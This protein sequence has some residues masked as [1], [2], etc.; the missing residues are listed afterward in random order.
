MIWLV[1]LAWFIARTLQQ[2]KCTAGC[3]KCDSSQENCLLCDFQQGMILDTGACIRAV[4]PG[5]LSYTFDGA[6]TACN[7]TTYLSPTGSCVGVPSGQTIANCKQYGSAS[8]CAICDEGYYVSKQKCDKLDNRIYGCLIHK[9]DTP[10]VCAVCKEGFRPSRDSQAC[11]P[12]PKIDN[13]R[14]YSD[15]LCVKCKQSY[16]ITPNNYIY[17]LTDTPPGT[18]ASTAG[19][20]ELLSNSQTHLLRSCRFSQIDNCVVYENFSRCKTCKENYF[21]SSEGRCVIFPTDSIVNCEVYVAAFVCGQ[22][23]QGYYL[24][25]KVSCL[26]VTP[27]DNCQLYNTTT[28]KSQCSECLPT[29][30]LSILSGYVCIARKVV[31]NNCKTYN[32]TSELCLICNP[33]FVT[34]DDKLQCLSMIQ[35][36]KIYDPSNRYTSALSCQFCVTG[37][38]FNSTSGLCQVGTVANCL[39]YSKNNACFTCENTYYLSNSAC[40]NHLP[41]PKC[42]TYSQSAANTC[43]TCVA[44]SFNFNLPSTCTQIPNLIPNCNSYQ[45]LTQC[46]KCALGYYLDSTYTCQLI[47]VSLNCLVLDQSGACIQCKT[48][49]VISKGLCVSISA[50]IT[51]N[52]GLNNADGLSSLANFACSYCRQNYIPVNF[53][54]LYECLPPSTVTSLINNCVRYEYNAQASSYSCLGCAPGYFLD[55]FGA[56]QTAC[57]VSDSAMSARSLAVIKKLDTGKYYMSLNSTINFCESNAN[58]N[59]FCTATAPPAF[60]FDQDTPTTLVSFCYR[61]N[62]QNNLIV[63]D[64]LLN[65]VGGLS[66]SNA[67][68]NFDPAEARA[69]SPMMNAVFPAKWCIS[70]SVTVK[71]SQ[72]PSNLV[73]NCQYYSNLKF[74]G[75]S[76]DIIGCL[77]CKFGFN[78]VVMNDNPG[79]FVG[80][81]SSCSAMAECDSTKYYQG[82]TASPQDLMY[83]RLPLTTYFSCHVCATAGM[84]PGIGLDFFTN[85]GYS[86]SNRRITYRTA[87]LNPFSTSVTGSTTLRSGSGGMSTAC[88]DPNGSNYG[89][90]INPGLPSKCGLMIF[91]IYAYFVSSLTQT[92]SSSP[93]IEILPVYCAACSPGYRPT[94][95]GQTTTA[96]VPYMVTACT[97]IS[98]CNMTDT[99]NWFNSCSKCN[100]GYTWEW[101]NGLSVP[102]L[103]SCVATN[104]ANCAYFNVATGKCMYCAS[105]YFFSDVMNACE[106]I[107][108]T[109][110]SDPSVVYSNQTFVMP[111]D[112][113]R[114]NYAATLFYLTPNPMSCTSCIN[115]FIAVKQYK[116]D[117]ICSRSAL[118]TAGAAYITGCQNHYYNSNK[119]ITCLICSADYVLS[120]GGICFINTKL[121]NC[122]LASSETVCDQCKTGFIFLNQACVKGSIANCLTYTF[123][124]LSNTQ[125]CAQC[126]SYYYSTSSACARGEIPFC[127]TYR[128]QY[129]C[130]ACEPGYAPVTTAN[131]RS[132]CYMIDPALKCSSFSTDIQNGI[133][134]C[135]TCNIGHVAL[136]SSLVPSSYCMPVQLVNNCATYN[137]GNTIAS[138]TFQCTTCSTNYYMSSINTCIPRTKIDKNCLKIDPNNDRCLTCSPGYFLGPNFLDCIANPTGIL[139]CLIYQDASTCT[140]CRSEYYPSSKICVKL[141]PEAIISNCQY[142]ASLVACA[143]CKQ[144]YALINNKCEQANIDNCSVYV[145]KNNCQTCAE[146]HAL[147]N[148]NGTAVCVSIELQNCKTYTTV[149]PARCIECDLPFYPDINGICQMVNVTIPNCE[150]YETQKTCLRCNVG[151]LLS[152]DRKSCL[153]GGVWTLAMDPNC[154]E[155][156]IITPPACSTCQLGYYFSEGKCIACTIENC[157]LCNPDSPTNC[158]ICK[159]G[160]YQ[161]KKGCVAY[162][163]PS[164]N[165]KNNTNS[166]PSD[167]AKSVPISHLCTALFFA[168]LAFI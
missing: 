30:Y 69:T 160:F 122:A 157:A 118:L 51:S 108:M 47:A 25:D 168:L 42:V 79:S 110:C 135:E 16:A 39:T 117:F 103:D 20:V 142:Y 63:W 96:F 24:A 8:S 109:F 11:V 49:L 152:I 46:S 81:I 102:Q 99:N 44:D 70:T 97:V 57:T 3:S 71:N 129:I 55:L 22:C 31:I 41:I 23:S 94:R 107:Q 141:P 75:G 64:F 140:T 165:P 27:L 60:G 19:F 154:A 137:I 133:L 2:S 80:Y 162:T 17:S 48:G 18:S 126:E 114:T 56:C 29:H 62:S 115:G 156:R 13:C 132:Y 76:T 58:T 6:C 131:G 98:N 88:Y 127:L 112:Y 43:S 130:S 136:S 159:S 4:Y 146:K 33:G 59:Q 161:T 125:V 83:D 158:I 74:S 116:D 21:L 134:R 150:T 38:T 61:C 149:Y 120:T 32:Q 143:T 139:G 10:K 144:G 36:C 45:S 128:S 93:T 105:G 35:D 14:H 28:S 153:Q 119:V 5:C 138:S 73:E 163:L 12:V 86:S 54:D 104:V 164:L 121:P 72:A 111:T 78:G 37:M 91:N 77:R 50:H 90:Q 148:W 145:D 123:T 95:V 101:N 106:S 167:S 52:C 26:A 65:P 66:I 15:V 166:I 147:F 67:V 124:K 1:G 85:T 113:Y 53:K 82:L 151:F 68:I 89:S 87:S 34:T 9:Q 7:S 155:N 92:T 100:S 40:L 84:L